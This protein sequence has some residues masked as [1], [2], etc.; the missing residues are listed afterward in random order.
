LTSLEGAPKFFNSISVNKELIIEEFFTHSKNYRSNYDK[1]VGSN[2]TRVY[3]EELL[4]FMIEEKIDLDRV[5]GWP[6]GF[7]ND[8]VKKSAKG[9]LKYKL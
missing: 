3:W 2:N 4:K 8:N 1:I 9:T 6:E 5:E 7:L